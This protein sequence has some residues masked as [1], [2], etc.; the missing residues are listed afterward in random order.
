MKYP[1]IE[2]SLK[3][4]RSDLHCFLSGGGLRVVRVEIAGKLVG[5][6]EHPSFEVAMDY[7]EE[8][9]AAGGRNYQDVYGP[10]H[11]HY[12]TGSSDPSSNLD[13]WILKGSNL[14]IEFKRKREKFAVRLNGHQDFR[15]PEEI[16]DEVEKNKM[17]I[18]WRTEGWELESEPFRFATG[19]IGTSTRTISKP[20]EADILGPFIRKVKPVF[21]GETLEAALQ[22]AE[23]GILEYLDHTHIKE[24]G[25]DNSRPVAVIRGI[26]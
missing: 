2:K 5:Y 14:D 10:I 18:S 15:M 13:R 7:T 24:W 25:I 9:V 6:G 16:K 21:Y 1:S 20:K 26:G 11:D 19:E 12:L 22:S 23:V 3:D 17:M 4:K 8:D